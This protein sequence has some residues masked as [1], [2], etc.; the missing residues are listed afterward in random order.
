MLQQLNAT[1]C[2]P[3]GST[4]QHGYIRDR[5]P[6]EKLESVVAAQRR[7]LDSNAEQYPPMPITR[8][9]NATDASPV[10]GAK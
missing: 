9:V 3:D 4:D 5:L 1:L 6:K 8:L 2:S 10:G 7:T